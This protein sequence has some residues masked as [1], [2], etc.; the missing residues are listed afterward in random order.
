MGTRHLTIVRK[1]NEL[2]VCQYGQW[3]GYLSGQGKTVYE[4][5]KKPANIEAL[6]QTLDNVVLGAEHFDSAVIA[7]D[8]RVDS[9]TMTGK[10]RYWFECFISRDV[11]ADILTNIIGYFP[12]LLPEECNEKICL[13]KYYNYDNL[14]NYSDV[15]IEYT[16]IIDL[17]TDR[18]EVWAYGEKIKDCDLHHMPYRKTFFREKCNDDD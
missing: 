6:R 8:L 17:D 3:D 11:G 12:K 18:L 15:N 16:Y 13:F 9:H 10:D 5:C 2:K 1:N 4:F 14:V 7:Y